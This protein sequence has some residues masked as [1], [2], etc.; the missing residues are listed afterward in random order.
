[1]KINFRGKKI[2]FQLQLIIYCILSLF[3]AVLTEGMLGMLLY[4]VSVT[5]GPAKHGYGRDEEF[6][7]RINKKCI[8]K[9]FLPDYESLQRMEKQTAVSFALVIIFFAFIFYLFYFW[10]LTRG[11]VKDMAYISTGIA[12]I[13]EGDLEEP[14]VLD[15]NDELGEIVRQVNKMSKEIDRM[16]EAE[17]AAMQTNKDMIA[18]IAHDLR[19]PVTSIAGYL[20]LATDVKTYTLEERQNYAR[21]AMKKSNRLER[22]IEELF[23][24]TKL[25]TGE[26]SLH[27]SEVDIVKLVEQMLEEFYPIFQ[28]NK[29]DCSFESSERALVLNV[30][31]EL[32]ARAVQNLLSNATKYGKDGKQILVK[33]EKL[34]IEVH[35][36]VTNFGIIIP[37]ES[38]SHLF[39]KFY[40][41]ENS[42]SAVT[43]GTG[44]GLNIAQEITHLHGGSIVAKSGIQ[45]TTFTI[46]LPLFGGVE[47]G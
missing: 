36:S 6:F 23:S 4:S 37:E 25:M 10:L 27:R 26:I 38:V 9:E 12:R 7:N 2:S 19:T 34:E 42:R 39:D 33:I 46:A 40:R 24:Y 20:Q 18:C 3:L 13:A 35:I 22:L 45:G 8:G 44:L 28:E 47:D 31:G 11:I 43:G 29:L 1:M 14:L 5:F 41:V 15:R 17:F 21:I 16:I 32:I 30:D